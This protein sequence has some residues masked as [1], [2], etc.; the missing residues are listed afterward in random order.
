MAEIEKQTETEL[1]ET[2]TPQTPPKKSKKRL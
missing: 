2:E 1:P